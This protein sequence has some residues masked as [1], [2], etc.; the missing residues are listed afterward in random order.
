[1]IVGST[2]SQSMRAR[3]RFSRCYDG[4][5]KYVAMREGFWTQ[6]SRVIYEN[7]AMAKALLFERGC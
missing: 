7:G 4:D 1:V 3:V 5:V 2:V 6:V